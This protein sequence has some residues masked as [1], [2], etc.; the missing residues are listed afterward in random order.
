[1]CA[2]LSYA[3]EVMAMVYHPKYEMWVI[4]IFAVVILQ[5]TYCKYIVY[6]LDIKDIAAVTMCAAASAVL[7]SPLP[8][9]NH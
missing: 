7:F 8:S 6:T 2:G 5:Q 9:L 3:V 4:S 1:M